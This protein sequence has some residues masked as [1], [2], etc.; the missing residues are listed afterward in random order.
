MKWLWPGWLLCAITAGLFFYVT[1]YQTPEI[2]GL[3][4][5]M[6]LPDAVPLG[7]DETAARSLFAAF[8]ADDAAARVEGRQS[9]SAAYV[10]MHAGYDLIF[11]PLLA[12]SLGFCAFAALYAR[13]KQVEIPRLAGVGLG[14]VLA[15]AFAY[16]GCDFVENAV[17]DTIFGPKALQ[18][19]FN[20]QMVFVLQVLTR[21]KY[22]SL[23]IAVVLI[24]ALWLWRWSSSRQ[25][26]SAAAGG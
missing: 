2:T 11:P 7:Y 16:L 25:Q 10:A 3:L 8:Q 20:Q 14:L 18:L 19:E 1:V 21:G 5:G 26:V 4:G 6:R 9:A 12:V 17:A 22:L 15:L 13:S 24:I 23:V